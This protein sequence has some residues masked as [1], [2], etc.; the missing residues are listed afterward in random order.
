MIPTRLD[1]P[2]AFHQPPPYDSHYGFRHGQPTQAWCAA[3]RA[4]KQPA[5]GAPSR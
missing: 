2:D 3:R 1:L 4:K 5:H